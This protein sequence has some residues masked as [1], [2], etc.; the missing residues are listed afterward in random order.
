MYI[1]IQNYFPTCWP[2]NPM[3]FWHL[4]LDVSLVSNTTCTQPTQCHIIVLKYGLYWIYFLL[5]RSPFFNVFNRWNHSISTKVTGR[6]SLVFPCQFLFSHIQ[7]KFMAIIK[8]SAVHL[9]FD[10]PQHQN[11]ERKQKFFPVDLKVI[12][13]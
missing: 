4:H 8:G 2:P 6:L 5:F 12:F 3:G 10:N 7:L 11:E 9:P 1:L 13:K